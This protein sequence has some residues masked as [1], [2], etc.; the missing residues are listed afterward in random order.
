MLS[1]GACQAR[2][3]GGKTETYI[4]ASLQESD[5]IC[6][7]YHMKLLSSRLIDQ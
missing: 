7:S 3:D 2:E 6:A 4:Q 5:L 1:E